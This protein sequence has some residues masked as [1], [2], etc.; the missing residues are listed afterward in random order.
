MAT[1]W[2]LHENYE[3]KLLLQ[4]TETKLIVK[5]MEW[6]IQKKK[7]VVFFI[8][9]QITLQDMLAKP[10]PTV[11]KMEASNSHSYLLLVRGSIPP[12]A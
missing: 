5:K 12:E 11:I 3:S 2:F 8:P 1:A 10:L 7:A 4:A 9:R 6:V